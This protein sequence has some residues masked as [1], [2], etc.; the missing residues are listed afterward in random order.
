MRLLADAIVALLWTC[1]FLVWAYFVT[2]FCLG[3][4]GV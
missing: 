4:V 1:G 2:A 3:M